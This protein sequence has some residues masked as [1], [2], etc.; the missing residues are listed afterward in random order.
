MNKKD[1]FFLR[2][3]IDNLVSRIKGEEFRLDKQIPLSYLLSFFFQKSVA[4][5]YGKLYFL[6]KN[7][8]LIHP[9]SKIRCK[10]LL[11]FGNNLVI[12]RYCYIDALSKEGIKL[13]KNVSIG[14]Y[15]TIDCTGS[16]RTLGKGLVVG[17]NVGLGTHGHY[18]CAG[19]LYIGSD[20]IMGNYVSFHPENH[21]FEILDIPIRLQGVNHKGIIIGK[22]CWIGAKVTILDGTY[23][24]DGCIVAAGAVVKG[25]FENNSIIG[26]IPAK[27]IKLR[28]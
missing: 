6:R 7:R 13:G 28:Q 1:D 4:L 14:R 12:D 5:I 25:T 2:T 16:L 24:G 27:T 26:G 23:L 21:N 22:N 18:G 17:D 20:T 11:Q 9:T 10:K 8:I 3:Q 19:G 15:T